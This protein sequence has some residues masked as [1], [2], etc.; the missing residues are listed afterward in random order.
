MI[1]KIL[2]SFLI[3]LN[4]VVVAQQ[5]ISGMVYKEASKEPV[6]FADV[7]I[8]GTEY[9]ITT[10]NDGSFYLETKENFKELT[11]SQTGFIT[12]K[13]S[14]KA[15]N[16]YEL[17]IYLKP[18]PTNE[19]NKNLQEVRVTGFKKFKSKKE[20]PA[21]AIL[22]ELWKRRRTNG[23]KK[24][25]NYKFDEYEKIEFDLNNLDSAFM[26]K[27]I[28]RKLEFIFNSVDTSNVTGKS[29][30]PMYLNE[31]IYRVIGRNKPNVKQ[32]RDLLASKTSGFQ[33]N[34]I[35]TETAKNLYK[36]SDIYENRLN[37]FDM[38]FVSPV[39]TDGFAF[40]EY[41]LLDTLEVEGRK[42]YKIKYFPKRKSDFTFKGKMCIDTEAYSLKSIDY[43]STK[44]INVN[45]VRDIYTELDFQILNDSVFL[46][47]RKY[48]MLDLSL[49]TKK[50]KDKGMFAHR[51][52]VFKN[53]DFNRKE[54]DEYFDK[55]WDPYVEGAYEKNDEY[56]KGNR[57]EKL[58]KSENEIYVM[59]DS[60]NKT[61]KFKRLVNTAE[62]V[63]SGYYN[64]FNAFDIGNIYSIYGYNPIEGTRIRLGGRTYF[65][66]NDMWRFAGFMAYGFK[67]D[68]VKYGAE[69]RFMFNKYN[70]FIVGIG[71]KRDIE[72]LGVQL[73]TDDGILTRTFA[74]SSLF[75]RGDNSTL[76]NVHKISVFT[77]VEPLK[78]FQLRFDATYQRISSASPT[79]NIGYLD[80]AGNIQNEVTDTHFTLALITTPYAKYTNYGI[81]RYQHSS[82]SPS[83]VAKYT[84]GLNGVFNSNFTYE[85]FQILYKHP[86][87]WGVI[88]RSDIT[89]EAG[90]TFGKVP[91][92]LLSVI[93]ANQSRSIVGSTFGQMNY[94]E[95]ITDT[96]LSLHWEHHDNGK[97]FSYI[98]LIKK[99]NLRAVGFLRGVWGELDDRN[100]AINASSINYLAP[101]N[102]IYYEYGFGVENIGIGNWRIFRI[103]FGWRGNYLDLPNISKFGIKFGFQMSF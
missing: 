12:Q 57:F 23:V 78:N 1:K 75:A 66:Q 102:Q 38:A 77:S 3:L 90:K 82:L 6:A 19:T 50:E 76:S 81:D 8:E 53:Y 45:F 14:L 83:I 94:Y 16:N 34:Q 55:R 27:K 48:V 95:F 37:Y 74:S 60:L 58:S 92:S 89:V 29:Y 70:R 47:E 42:C 15:G 36:D 4:I 49:L 72:Q 67:D 79:F 9:Y 87:L 24:F 91:L 2:F 52:Q 26:K 99:L 18:E 100:V 97:I 96:Y 30:L 68:K 22:R 103:D 73:T 20:N 25:E 64:V 7:L 56:W 62:I 35:V 17:I 80:K 88:G 5:K 69:A 84:H 86:V 44:G 93:P 41:Q 46:P 31:N 10:N 28:F 98:P 71:V 85:K 39:A 13:V 101:S 33:D 54:N 61:P 63:A 51:T 65:S 11:V 59:L 43:Q 32:R 21:Y 40:Y